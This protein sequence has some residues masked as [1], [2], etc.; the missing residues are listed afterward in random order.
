MM[1]LFY[2]S[3]SQRF[4]GLTLLKG[5]AFKGGNIQELFIKSLPPNLHL[6][7]FEYTMWAL[8][9]LETWV[10]NGRRLAPKPYLTI[11]PP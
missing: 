10:P 1:P 8:V 11:H 4:E 2:Q 6:T 9:G 5:N 3:E 7:G